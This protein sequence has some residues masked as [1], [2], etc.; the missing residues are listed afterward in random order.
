MR[1]ITAT[2]RLAHPIQGAGVHPGSGRGPSP[3]C[4]GDQSAPA[5]GSLLLGRGTRTPA[6][7]CVR[8]TGTGLP[9]A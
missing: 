7:G 1:V 9:W 6:G 2:A 4:L 8:G 5:R 3:C